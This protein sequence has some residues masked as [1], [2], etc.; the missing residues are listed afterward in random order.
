MTD[1]RYCGCIAR[2]NN[3]AELSAVPQILVHCCTLRRHQL[4]AAREAWHDEGAAARGL[5]PTTLILAYDSAYTHAQCTG[6]L[7]P[8]ATNTTVIAV[9]RRL[10]REAE[11]LGIDVTWVKVR[12]H[13]KA[14]AT[15]ATVIGNTWAEKAAD[16]GQE[17]RS[18]KERSVATYIADWMGLPGHYV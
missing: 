3:T 1:P 5:P 12:W 18:R 6:R 8:A 4:G 15:D 14:A 10:L 9:C 11:S 2:S 16:N 7:V 13:S 17:G